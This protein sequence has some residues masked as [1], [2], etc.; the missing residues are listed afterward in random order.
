MNTLKY[1]SIGGA[2][3]GLIPAAPAVET[4]P[5]N[6][7]PEVFSINGASR[8]LIPAAPA[9]ETRLIFTPTGDNICYTFFVVAEVIQP[10]FAP[11]VHIIGCSLFAIVSG[12]HRTN[13]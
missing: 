12:L 1:V 11:P 10:L 3:R 5:N 13:H 8:G 6:E 4:K 9:V 2:S 7:H